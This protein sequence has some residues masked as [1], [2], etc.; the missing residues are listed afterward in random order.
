MRKYSPNSKKGRFQSDPVVVE[1]KFSP[2]AE[3]RNSAKKMKIQSVI[4][5]KKITLN[6]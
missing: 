3:M 6:G 1:G 2:F 5:K 4:F